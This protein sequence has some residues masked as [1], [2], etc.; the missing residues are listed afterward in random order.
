MSFS[1]ITNTSSLNAQSDLASTQSSLGSTLQR[2]SS[3][4]RINNSGDDPAG[5][6]I[7]NA[8]RNQIATVTQGSA[9]ANEATNTLQIIDGGLNT[10]SGLLDQATTLASQSASGTFTGNRNTL[11]QSLT[12]LL[13]EIDR[14]AQN[15]GLGGAAGTAEGKYNQNLNVYVGGGSTSTSANNQVNINLANSRVDSIGLGLTGLNIGDGTG[16]VTGAES[17][18]GGITAA[19]TLTFQTVGSS[20]QLSS[21]NIALS[22][23]SSSSNVLDAINNDAN[24]QAAGISATVNS[25]GNLVLSSSGFF[26]VSSN[27]ADGAGQTG[28]AG[29]GSAAG[30]I[31]VTG[32]ANTVS[33]A[34]SA[35]TAG[36]TQTLAFTGQEIGFQ[37]TSHNVS[38]AT[39]ATAAASATSIV[40]AV[41]ND[42]TLQQ[43]GVF[44]IQTKADGS[45]VSFVSLKNFNLGISSS[46]GST[47]ATNNID[48]LQTSTAATAG[49]LTG[50][51]AGAQAA[52]TAIEAA[53]QSLGSVQG[54]VGSAEN[55][56][57]DATALLTS[58]IN[59]FTTAESGIRDANV[60]TEASNLARLTVLQQ[61]GV[62]A[63]AQA[64]TSSQ[65]LLKLLQ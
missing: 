20:G 39:S 44:A 34:V 32:A 46:A 59:N 36:A 52:I 15:T 24:A 4:L 37:D 40:N 57:N 64:N 5:L 25:S 3:G 60:A 14:E 23:G 9:N 65:S 8:L 31:A 12:G 43:A 47:N 38:F 63:L 51:P 26:T 10:I 29:A 21:F 61:S 62:S 17:L 19:E 53:V 22:A 54:A 27:Q 11:Q 30:D 2:L 50:G 55:T 49:V 42:N 58:Q 18:S 41:N 35:G 28:I 45:G 6:A 13:A 48:A 7:A 1:L 16:N 33:E 56:I